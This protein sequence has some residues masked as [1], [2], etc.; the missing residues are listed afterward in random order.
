MKD[1]SSTKVEINNN[2][3]SF[4]IIHNYH[5]MEF[6]QSDSKTK[7]GYGFGLIPREKTNI[8]YEN[9]TFS[10]MNIGIFLKLIIYGIYLPFSL[11][12]ECKNDRIQLSIYTKDLNKKEPIEK[13]IIEN[14]IK[15]KDTYYNINDKQFYFNYLEIKIDDELYRD[16]LMELCEFLKRRDTISNSKYLIIKILFIK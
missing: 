16:E 9:I 6:I 4:S 2:E 14:E 15:V 5:K 3:V 7:Y 8:E 13:L 10:F 12:S 1:I 11:Y